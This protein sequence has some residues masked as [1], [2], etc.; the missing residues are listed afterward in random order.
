MA[1]EFCL[2]EI[3]HNRPIS[4]IVY[5]IVKRKDLKIKQGNLSILKFRGSGGLKQ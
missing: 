2:L 1:E 4:N 5:Y 3:I